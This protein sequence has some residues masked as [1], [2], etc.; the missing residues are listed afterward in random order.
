MAA[1]PEHI[2]PTLAAVD[3]AIE[4]AQDC[5]P[6]L[7][8]GMSSIGSSCTRSLWYDFRWVSPI[9]FDAIVLKRFEDGHASE[10][11]QADRLRKVSSIELLTV[12][13]ETGQQFGIEDHGGH[14]RGHMDGAIR[15][16][17]QSPKT[18]HVWEHKA[19]GDKKQAELIRA[20]QKHGEKEALIN[21]NR[22]YYAQA[23][24]Y[25]HY[26][27][28]ERH[29]LTCSTPGGRTTVSVRT[30]YIRED[31]LHFVKRASEIISAAEPPLRVSEKPDWY[32][33][34]WCNHRSCC[35]SDTIPQAHCRTCA[36]STPVDGGWKCEAHGF[37]LNRQH[38]ESGC[39]DHLFIPGLLH[40]AEMQDADNAESPPQWVRY[41]HIESGL[42]F[43]NKA[44][45]LESSDVP[46]FTSRE[47]AGQSGAIIGDKNIAEMKGPNWNGYLLPPKEAETIQ[48]EFN[49]SL[50]G[51]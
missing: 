26:T 16:I 15:G 20:K 5:K 33:C 6:R 42:V 23:Q 22:A 29:Y 39:K 11:V 47:M 43:L 50:K 30:N 12:D 1:I 36:H 37:Q 41:K 49:D 51:I 7:Y 8:L 38:Q 9:H 44:E 32:E 28:M 24:C 3:Q 27:G 35:H 4:S 19:V 2:D 40:W 48:T 31:A 25:M 10:A 14:F 46:A 34:S 18:W 13:S 45:R 17:L 21:W